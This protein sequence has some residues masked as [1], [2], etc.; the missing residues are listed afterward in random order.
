VFVHGE[1]LAQGE[2][3]E[4]EV[5]VAAAEEWEQANHVE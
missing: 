2:V 1:L 3:L 5:A 4:R